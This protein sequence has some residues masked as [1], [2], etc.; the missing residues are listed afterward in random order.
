M[1]PVLHTIMNCPPLSTMCQP[2]R[3]TSRMRASHPASRSTPRIAR[4]IMPPRL[5]ALAPKTICAQAGFAIEGRKCSIQGG[6]GSIPRGRNG[7]DRLSGCATSQG[8]RVRAAPGEGMSVPVWILG[9]PVWR[10][11]GGL[12]GTALRLCRPFCAPDSGRSRQNLS[13]D[14][15]AVPVSGAAL[16]H[17]GDGA[18][19]GGQL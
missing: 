5:V 13:R 3:R 10:A 11:A 14:L 18:V 7:A 6:F 9:S 19:C 8:A 2:R 1:S 12:S 17:D 16:F 15:S 4:R